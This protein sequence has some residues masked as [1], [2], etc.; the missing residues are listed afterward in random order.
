[1][2][3]F[4]LAKEETDRVYDLTS[5]WSHL[6]TWEQTA[7]AVAVAVLLHLL[8]RMVLLQ[9]MLRLAASTQ[10]DLDDRLVYFVRRFYLFLLFFAFFLVI[11]RIH[12]VEITPFLASAGIVG[13]AIGLA[14]KETLSDIL[15]GVFLIADQPIRIGDRIKVES[16]GRHW[17]GWGDV[18]DVGLRRTKVRNTDG[19]I[20]NYPNNVLANSIITNF[21]YEDEPIRV[22][23]RFQV[24]YDCDLELACEVA[25]KAIE[26][27][28]H[29]I[30]DSTNVVVRSLWDDN[31]G[32][33]QSGI[34][35]EGRYRI[36]DVRDRTR[37]RSEVLIKLTKLLRENDI[38][39]A[40]PEVRI[41]S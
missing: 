13:I 1:M 7:I 34:L 10:N 21:S 38:S 36:D 41:Q 32:H 4:L 11:L 25:K 8:V 2:I 14:A 3:A 35:L 24:N 18:V 30:A 12:G 27:T 22:R 29:V 17:G 31:G 28:E 39:L 15:S 26:C 5:L 19:V 6:A 33:M 37:I 20:V 23:V 40:H 9:A 16:I